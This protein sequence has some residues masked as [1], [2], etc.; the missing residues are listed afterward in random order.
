M[1]SSVHWCRLM[2]SSVPLVLVYGKLCTLGVGLWEAL[3]PWC[4]LWE[5]LYIGVSNGK[6]CIYSGQL[7]AGY[8]VHWH[9]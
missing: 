4:R 5:A 1:G 8:P 2:G 7:R 9:Y 6:H 3:Y